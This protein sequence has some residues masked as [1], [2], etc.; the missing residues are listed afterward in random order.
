M[1]NDELDN[2]FG[3][4]NEK[5]SVSSNKIDGLTDAHKLLIVK[6]CEENSDN[7]PSIEELCKLVSPGENLDGRSKIGR[8]IKKYLVELNLKAKT[9]TEYEKKGLLEL[10]PEQKEYIQKNPNEKVTEI[11]CTIFNKPYLAPLSQEVQTVLAYQKELESLGGFRRTVEDEDPTEEYRPP[12]TLENVCARINKHVEGANFDSKKL[13][14]TQKKQCFNLISYMKSYRFSHNYNLINDKDDRYLF[15]NTFL[16]YIYNKTDLSQEDLDQYLSLAN[17][18]VNESAIKRNIMRLEKDQEKS[19]E[20]TG[21]LQMALVDAIKISRDE[22]NAC[23]TR[24]DKLY[25][26]L[27]LERSKRLSERVGPQFT[28]LNIVEEMK[29]EERRKILI[30]EAQK[31]NEKVKG[32]IKRLSELDDTILRIWGMDEDLIING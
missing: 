7:P 17:E 1:E 15:E 32:E 29:N 19:L 9:K 13:T 23:R 26:A 3:D 16:K 2:I 5:P 27:E 31:R 10:T 14:P 12:R 30:A 11:A 4:L 6:K 28:L 22:Y 18:A 21:R 8:E 24:Q 20:E 25:K